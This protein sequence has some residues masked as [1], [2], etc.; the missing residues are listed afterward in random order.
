MMIILVR[1]KPK[2]KLIDIAEEPTPRKILPKETRR[3]RDMLKMLRKATK[4]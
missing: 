4:M 2:E 1:L 3:Q